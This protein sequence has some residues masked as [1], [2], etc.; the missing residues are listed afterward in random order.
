MDDK[1]QNPYGFAPAHDQ[2]I[3]YMDR[4]RTYYQTLGYG[5]PY[6][7]AH[8]ADVPFQPLKKPLADSQVALI[9]SAAPYQPGKGDQGPGAAYNASAKFYEVYSGETAKDHDLRISHIGYDRN[10]TT[11]EDS[12][13]WF[14][15]AQLRRLASE[16]RIGGLTER[17]H[18]APTNRSH[19]TTIEI[20]CAE[21]LARC[22]QDGADVAVIVAN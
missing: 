16:G 14:P 17:F 21:I 11:A 2:P 3:R 15:L 7:W 1:A 20:D 18:G 4:I 22:R 6:E 8:F 5:K 19:R 10:H 13:T 9:T 12:R